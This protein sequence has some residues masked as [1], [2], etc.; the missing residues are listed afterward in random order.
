LTRKS[1]EAE[2]NKD[3]LL[4]N[5]DDLMLI[6]VKRSNSF[7]FSKLNYKRMKRFNLGSKVDEIRR[8]FIEKSMIFNRSKG[9][10][11]VCEFPLLIDFISDSLFLMR[12]ECKGKRWI[13]GEWTLDNSGVKNEVFLRFSKGK[14]HIQFSQVD[15]KEMEGLKYFK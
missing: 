13:F 6:D 8:N 1:I 2:G 7:E 9:Y 15:K 12:E 11:E 3:F 4:L 10:G 5:N 14:E